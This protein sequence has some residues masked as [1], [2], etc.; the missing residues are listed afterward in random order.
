MRTSVIISVVALAILI[1]VASSV[2][3]DA[4]REK[5]QRL[6][7]DLVQ[8]QNFKKT[9]GKTY[10]NEAEEKARFAVF[11]SN[12]VRIS[13][14]NSHKSSAT[15]KM[16]KFGDLSAD[17]FKRQYMGV[18]MP[19]SKEDL[20]LAPELEI[21]QKRAPLPKSV[22]WRKK[23]AV[24]PVKDQ[25]QCGSC[26]AFS[27]VANIEGQWFLSGHNLTSLSE[28]FLV[29]CDTTCFTID[30]QQECNQGCNGGLMSSAFEYVIKNKGIDA[31]KDY[32]Y[33]ASDNTCVA[34]QNKPAATIS[35]WTMIPSNETQMAAWLAKQ[36]PLSIAVDAN[37]WQ[38]YFGG[39]F[40]F[41]W[42]GS[43]LD[44]GVT[45]VG[46]GTGK[47]FLDEDTDYW[48]IKN[49]WGSG[50]GESGYIRMERGESLC[51]ITEFPCTSFV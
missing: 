43:S 17:E 27:T 37:L 47:N 38:F 16:N 36:G 21:D 30:N 25:G 10:K 22:D 6:Q 12:L 1:Q 28:Q 46:Y 39:I 40:D 32:P 45:L 13:E 35:S 48:V 15:F 2:S 44:H 26:W 20:P 4:E 11:R 18:R 42:C 51:G 7:K 50:W 19:Q 34:K 33:T 24:T 23:G 31:E 14:L 29:D 9:H 49:S 5:I 3:I 8:F 41:Y